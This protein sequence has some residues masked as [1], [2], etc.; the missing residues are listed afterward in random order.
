MID[1]ILSLAFSM[2][3][4]KGV[5][6]LL[7]GSGISR[8]AGIPTGWEITLDLI[9][10]LA[11]LKKENCEPDPEKWF[12]DTFQEEANYSKL[13]GLVA[14]TSSERNKLLRA[15]FDPTDEERQQNIK[16]PTVAHKTIA[17]LVVKGYIKVIL[18]TNFD[19][20][21]EK[22]LEEAGINP[23]VIGTTD[24]IKGAEPIVHSQCTVIKLHGDY[25]D[26]RIKNTPE[27]LSE[28]DPE[29]NNLIDRI[30]DDFGLII[31]GWSGKWDTA[32]CNAIKRCKSHR[33]T[34]FWAIKDNPSEEVKNLVSFRK[35]EILSIKSAD[36][37]FSDLSEKLF[38]INDFELPH[39]LSSRIAVVNFKKYLEEEK[40]KIRLHDLLIHET[41]HL[42]EKINQTISPTK[43]PQ[44]STT[45]FIRQIKLFEAQTEI[46]QA[47]M[48]TGGYWGDGNISDVFVKCL[49]RLANNI[50]I[51]DGYKV[52]VD[53]Q[54]YPIL[55]LVFPSCLAAIASG[56]YF[57]LSNLLLKPQNNYSPTGPEPLF[58]SLFPNTVIENDI[59][60]LLPNMEKRKTPA[61]DY[62][63][64]LI[65]EPLR[66]FIPDQKE[67]EDY[68][69]R[70]EYLASLCFM[71]YRIQAS[72]PPWCPMGRF[73]WRHRDYGMNIS[74]K[75]QKEINIEKMDWKPL[76]FG[77]FGG[78]IE[79][80]HKAQEMVI[81][82][83]DQ[84][85]II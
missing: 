31:C 49:E 43:L 83:L 10:K 79:R 55:L 28:Y 52:W 50:K 60:K 67:L 63:L 18:T 37:F 7:L 21:L 1:P 51:R 44:P 53:I 54:Y 26:N 78:L 56:N 62:L 13:L 23:V 85:I 15:Y 5:Y 29:L 80:V 16:T 35:A 36:T 58:L 33:Y 68:F 64:E 59:A 76:K 9:K 71:D 84:I 6:A 75:I 38:G 27:E 30:F 66:E 48:I 39:P 11:H 45:E 12:E 69:D 57:M 4:N 34:T 22:S 32:L 42:V 72:R 74:R 70:L 19:R 40:Y 61:S 3:S 46:L 41:E 81:E 47:M 25:L 65:S 8:S 73:V 17:D 20:L 14:K 82:R 2:N 24:A 77:F